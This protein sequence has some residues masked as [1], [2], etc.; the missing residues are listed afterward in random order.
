LNINF[1]CCAYIRFAFYSYISTHGINLIFGQTI[2]Y[3]LNRCDYQM[4]YTYPKFY[5]FLPVPTQLPI[6]GLLI[7]FSESII[8]WIWI[9]GLRSGWLY[10]IEF[11]IILYKILSK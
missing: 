6:W 7:L 4:F 8:H 10:R 11:E 2:L 3:L 5:L 9:M 1:K